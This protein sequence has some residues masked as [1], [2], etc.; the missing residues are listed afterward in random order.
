M[1]ILNEIGIK[2]ETEGKLC[3]ELE[4]A[5]S[6]ED[7]S[8]RRCIDRLAIFAEDSPEREVMIYVD[9]APRSFTFVKKIQGK[10]AGNGGII[11]HGSHDRGGD[12]G[13][14]TF[15]VNLEPTYGWQIHT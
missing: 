5:K 4:Y 9:F 10:F 12:G 2:D 11:W 3:K 1:E 13:A 7:N 14:P 8:L 6:I 15:S